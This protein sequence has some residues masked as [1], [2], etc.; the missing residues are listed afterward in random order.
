MARQRRRIDTRQHL[1]ERA[2]SDDGTDCS[3]HHAIRARSVIQLE[4]G[5][6]RHTSQKQ[7]TVLRAALQLVNQIGRCEKKQPGENIGNETTDATTEESVTVPGAPPS[8][9]LLMLLHPNAGPQWP[10]HISNKTLEKMAATLMKGDCQGQLFHQYCVCIYVK[11]IGHFYQLSRIITSPI[12][13]VQLVQSRNAY[14]AA[15]LR[16]MRQFNI[17]ASPSL[18]SIQ[19]LVS[20]VSA[21]VNYHGLRLTRIGL[22]DA[23][24]GR[25]QTM[26]DFKL[27]RC[28]A[29]SCT[30][31][32]SYSQHTCSL[33][34]RRGDTQRRIL[35]LLY[36]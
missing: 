10:D 24:T 20:S 36:G 15:T 11:A 6:S 31:L 5:D 13:R 29:N 28:S 34:D 22:V 9:L 12:V 18:Q 27:I 14:I 3:N 16:S 32:R 1:E 2:E 19:S 30:R 26:L 23:A 8:E 17:L 7:Q 33:T 21:E 25:C 4:L 35:V